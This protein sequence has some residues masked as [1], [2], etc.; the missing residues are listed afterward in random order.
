M[1]RDTASRGARVPAGSWG[2]TASMPPGLRRVTATF[3]RVVP[4]RETGCIGLELGFRPTSA[5]FDGDL[6]DFAD[7]GPERTVSAVAGL[8]KVLRILRAARIAVP[9]DPYGLLGDVEPARAL[10]ERALGVRLAL[11]VRPRSQL[12]F[13]AWTED[14]VET[15]DHVADVLESDD[16]FV[17][18]RRDGR[19][20]VRVARKHVVRQRTDVDRWYEILGVERA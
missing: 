1:A 3:D 5:R 9:G 6:E 15:V 7:L 11:E 19:V 18:M 16:H 2:Y 17:V 14:G 20:P 10:L 13:T 4:Q 12:R 8:G